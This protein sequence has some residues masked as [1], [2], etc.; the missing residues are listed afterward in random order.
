MSATVTASRRK[1]R[2]ALP[3]GLVIGLGIL[4]IMGLLPFVLPLLGAPGAD[5]INLYDRFEKPGSL[6]HLLGSDHLGRDLLARMA[7]G[8]KWSFA[9]AILSTA[10]SLAIGA[11]LGL[12]AADQSGW[13]RR[14]ILQ[15]INLTM[16]F[17]SLVAAICLIA[18]IGQGFMSLVL[19][20]GLLTWPVFA[21]IVYA[22]SL[23]ILEKDYVI[24]ARFMGVK[25]WRILF[26]HVL[27]ALRPS[28][29]ATTAFHFADMLIAESALS[30]LG[31]GAP[32]DSSTWGNM[33][34][35]SRSFLFQAP[36]MMLVPAGAIVLVVVS[37]N[38]IGDGISTLLRGRSQ[39]SL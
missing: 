23:A 21:R 35:D 5:V 25:Q 6:S 32:I 10:L 17:P 38:L 28:L 2:T 34:A 26:R 13:P 31:I 39:R 3:T 24:A 20:L 12:L 27:P 30:F 18:I 7:V 11:P 15:I 14:V 36:W 4:V 29:L 22:E 16:S 37:A 33:L 8:F 9:A 1:D 19:V